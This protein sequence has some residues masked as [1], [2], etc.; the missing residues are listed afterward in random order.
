MRTDS[1]P[2]IAVTVKSTA[3]PGRVLGGIDRWIARSIPQDAAVLNIGAGANRSGELARVRGRAGRLVGVDP[4]PCIQENSQVDE[5]Y[6]QTIEQFAA[7]HADEFDLAFSVFVLEHVGDADGFATACARVLKPGGSLMGL[8]V[9]AWH[10][11][12]FITWATTRL[13]VAEWLM[14]QVRSAPHIED[15]PFPTEDRVN[16]VTA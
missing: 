9:N 3:P 15:Y 1:A 2:R 4:S 5:R 16:S 6:E 14:R 10:Y 7:G 12:G 13:G 8:T 11:F